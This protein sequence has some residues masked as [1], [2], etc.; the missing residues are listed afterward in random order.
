MM[1]ERPRTRH[2]GLEEDGPI[3]RIDDDDDD[4]NNNNNINSDGNGHQ[5]TY[6]EIDA[7]LTADASEDVVMAQNQLLFRGDPVFSA[8]EG[9]EEVTVDLPLGVVLEELPT[10]EV[11]VDEVEP[12]GNADKSGSLREGDIIVALSLPYGSGLTFVPEEDA[13]DS[14]E[15]FVKSRAGGSMT[16]AVKRGSDVAI[17]RG[18]VEK[19]LYDSITEE[20]IKLVRDAVR[21]EWY[22]FVPDYEEEDLSEADKLLDLRKS[23]YNMDVDI[24]Y[25]PTPN[26]IETADSSLSEIRRPGMDEEEE[27]DSNFRSDL[28]HWKNLYEQGKKLDV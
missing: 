9:M 22:P 8:L 14:V 16:F 15:T 1:R 13:L 7:V 23:G 25:D 21:T 10:G 28:L 18:H 5:V 6:R 2:L 19:A 24:K 20:Q 27:D 11:F 3:G 26:E 12:E 17:L 4:E